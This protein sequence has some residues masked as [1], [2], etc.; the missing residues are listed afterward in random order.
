[1]GFFLNIL[2]SILLRTGRNFRCV[3]CL[4]SKNNFELL[5]QIFPKKFQGPHAHYDDEVT[6]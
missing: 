1:M 6:G 4:K 3:L 5:S 2:P